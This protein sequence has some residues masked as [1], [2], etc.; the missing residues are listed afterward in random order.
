MNPA[1]MAEKIKHGLTK[2]ETVTYFDLPV[3]VRRFEYHPVAPT[4]TIS[5]EGRVARGK[6]LTRE[7][8]LHILNECHWN[9][10]E[11]ARRVGVSRTAIWKYMKKWDISLKKP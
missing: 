8:L 5:N 4:I 3:E 9:K 10:A 6:A 2:G 7:S 11:V 1:M